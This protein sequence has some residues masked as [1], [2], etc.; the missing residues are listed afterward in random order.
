[1]V[2][3]YFR[4][5]YIFLVKGYC[6]S[7]MKD[8]QIAVGLLVFSMVLLLIGA[9]FRPSQKTEETSRNASAAGDIEV[10]VV[11]D[12]TELA[13]RTIS[14]AY[15]NAN[16]GGDVQCTVY[17][18]SKHPVR[19]LLQQRVPNHMLRVTVVEDLDMLSGRPSVAYLLSLGQTQR[20]KIYVNHHVRLGPGWNTSITSALKAIP[21]NGCLT[22]GRAS[23]S[24][25]LAPTHYSAVQGVTPD[26]VVALKHLAFQK[27]QS[28]PVRALLF[29]GDVVATPAAKPLVRD[30][31]TDGLRGQAM[32]DVACTVIAVAS[33]REIYCTPVEFVYSSVERKGILSYKN[34]HRLAQQ[35]TTGTLFQETGVTESTMSCRHTLKRLGIRLF[36]GRL[37]ESAALGL[38]DSSDETEVRAKLGSKQALATAQRHV[39]K[40]SSDH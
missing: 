26:G 10:V 25:S 1:M 32:L 12:D 21:Q 28:Y 18:S 17:T 9:V 38:V 13:V 16:N 14:A 5:K 31:A 8:I 19:H 33:G 36:K 27:P 15:R 35:L 29:G 37:S 39:T 40:Y 20:A 6:A 7:G 11:S 23:K 22:A 4:D 30:E 2:F 24:T 34:D 3:Y